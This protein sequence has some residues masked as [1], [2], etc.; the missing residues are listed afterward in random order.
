MTAIHAIDDEI[1]ILKTNVE[2]LLRLYPNAQKKRI[3]LAPR[4][5]QHQEIG[6]MAWLKRSHQNLW[7]LVL[8]ELQDH[9]TKFS[10]G[11]AFVLSRV[12]I[13]Y[14]LPYLQVVIAMVQTCR[15]GA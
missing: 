11:N 2:D 3:E 8:K 6:H 4:E 5:W 1:A 10:E 7:P 9:W 12:A 15:T 13:K 14:R